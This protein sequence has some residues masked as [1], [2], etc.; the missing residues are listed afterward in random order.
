MTFACAH[1]GDSSKFRENTIAGIQSAITA[2]A[3][4]V[5]IDLR[6]SRDGEVIVSHDYT[7][8][9]MWGLSDDVGNRD[10]SEIAR[11]GEGDLR[12]PLLS[13]VLK[14]FVGTS[15]TLMIDMEQADPAAGAFA[16]VQSGP[17]SQ[18]QITWCGHLEGMR[19]IRSLSASARIWMPWDEVAI[20]THADISELNPEFINL[21]YSF[22]DQECVKAIHELG[23]KVSVWT[24]QDEAT[25][26]WAAAIGVDSITT[27]YLSKLQDVLATNPKLAADPPQSCTIEDI[28]VEQA[29][30]VAR[31]LGRW[32]AMVCRFMAP[33]ELQLKQN[34]ADIVTVVD[35]MIEKHVRE[36][37]SANFPGH[38]FVGEEFGGSYAADTPSWYLDP[39]DGTTNFAN[40][41]PW[42]SFSLALAH[43]RTPLLGVVTD[44]WREKIFEAQAGKGAMCNGQP[45]VIEV[46]SAENPLSS[47]IVATELAS[48]QPWPGMLSLLDQLA[49]NFCT[50]RIMGSG[51]LTLAGVAAN[52]SVGAVVGHF[53]PIDHLAACLI[54]HEAGGVVLDERGEVNLFPESGG[55]L[56]A[57][58]AAAKPLYEIW[59]KA[60]TF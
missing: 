48:Y 10:W 30:E 43:N 23:C 13:D 16:V 59:M 2:G 20:P 50:M 58:K 6:I 38:N 24:I 21:N 15:S 28:D 31:E 12:I 55:I 60:V 27:D 9:R 19:T 8:E 52:Q 44:P 37:I 3:E 36:V 39:V 7:L 45:L 26:R 14:L 34:P 47:R 33:G 53:S 25:M 35:L 54:V 32:S 29:M 46:Q 4:I 5:E 11:L 22:V 42:S 18:D 1:R 49:E 51:T 57:T 56:C 41:M 17:L 40:G